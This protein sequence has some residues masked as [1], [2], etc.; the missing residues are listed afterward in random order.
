[1]EGSI[2][3][4]LETRHTMLCLSQYD[5]VIDMYMYA[6]TDHWFMVTCDQPTIIVLHDMSMHAGSY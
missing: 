6:D 2:R 4:R 3:N 1:M 5:Q